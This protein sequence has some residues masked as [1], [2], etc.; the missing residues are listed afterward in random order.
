MAVRQAFFDRGPDARGDGIDLPVEPD[1]FPNVLCVETR[2]SEMTAKLLCVGASILGAAL[3]ACLPVSSE[4]AAQKQ[5]EQNV[6]AVLP[7][8]VADVPLEIAISRFPGGYQGRWAATAAG[9]ADDPESSEQMMSLQ[10]KLVKF[11]KSIGTMTQGKRQTSKTMEAE[12]EF[13]GEGDKWNRT[14]AFALSDDRKRITRTDK[15]DGA[16]YQYVECPKLMAG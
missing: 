13:V 3:G 12:F 10:G 7:A 1:A 5:A 14:I 16:T 2:K 6:S 15:D 11:H 4:D 8:E 9:C